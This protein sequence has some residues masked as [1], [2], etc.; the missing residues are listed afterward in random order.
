[1]GRRG[2]KPTPTDVL[3]LRG[4]W[5]ANINPDE[6]EPPK[7]KPVCPVRLT[8]QAKT[9]WQRMTKL[10]DEMNVLTLVD[11]NALCR[12]CLL[13]A[14]YVDV[15]KWLIKYGRNGNAMPIVRHEKVVAFGRLPQTSVAAQLC[16]QLLRLEQQFG[17]TPS[18]RSRMTTA[19]AP[20]E[21]TRDDIAART[22]KFFASA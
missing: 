1:M 8:G 16:D 12:Y 17:L 4:S 20:G 22:A 3:K 10:L 15:E 2:P 5:R 6:P 18:S 11:G 21:G 19:A 13:W 7:G 14:R 9:C